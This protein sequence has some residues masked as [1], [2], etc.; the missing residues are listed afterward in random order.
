MLF[1][2]GWLPEGAKKCTHARGCGE[3]VCTPRTCRRTSL[4]SPL[5]GPYSSPVS[6]KPPSKPCRC[7]MLR[8]GVQR[9]RL[10][11]WTGP[12]TAMK[13][14]SSTCLFGN[15]YHSP[16]FQRCSTSPSHPSLFTFSF[17]PRTQRT[18]RFCHRLNRPASSTSL[19]LVDFDLSRVTRAVHNARHDLASDSQQNIECSKKSNRFSSWL[20]VE[21]S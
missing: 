12:R 18:C 6:P 7:H 4:E 19:S 11:W 2:W 13:I 5:G 9:T 1:R 8:W 3:S 14:L 17:T 15:S 20:V 16:H 10:G 21:P